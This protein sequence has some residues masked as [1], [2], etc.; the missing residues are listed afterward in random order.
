MRLAS[1]I[2]VSLRLLVP[3]CCSLLT[4]YHNSCWADWPPQGDSNRKAG[5]SRSAQLKH[6]RNLGKN[7]NDRNVK[8]SKLNIYGVSL[9]R[10]FMEDRE[11]KGKKGA[12]AV[13]D[14]PAL[15]SMIVEFLQKTS[16]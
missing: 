9:H 12:A 13:G 4:H 3:C 1:P 2:H 15:A 7:T 16:V 6:S 10:Y 11:E 8:E 5:R 14:R